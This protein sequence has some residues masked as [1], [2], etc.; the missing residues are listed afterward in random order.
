MFLWRIQIMTVKLDVPFE[1][2]VELVKQ[3]P[4]QQQQMLLQQIQGQAAESLSVEAKIELLRAAQIDVSVNQE[5][6][7]RR[8]D[9]YS[10]EGR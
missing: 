7:P 8:Q 1:K 6:S 10:D 2:L 9:W 4:L 5:P 3:L